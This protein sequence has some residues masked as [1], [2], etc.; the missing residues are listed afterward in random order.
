MGH[1]YI[2]HNSIGHNYLGHN[3]IGHNYMGHKYIGHNYIGHNYM[4]HKYIGHYYINHDY[5]GRSNA[6]DSKSCSQVPHC[7]PKLK[8]V[9][10]L[11]GL[12]AIDD[13][14][15][16]S[17]LE[18]FLRTPDLCADGTFPREA[19]AMFDEFLSMCTSPSSLQQA[20]TT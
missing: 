15:R 4:G 17:L 13:E 5:T 3:Y 20:I 11:H 1:N 19:V 9:K 2:G 18:L 14:L 7:M 12:S 16:R 6:A 8:T 10:Y